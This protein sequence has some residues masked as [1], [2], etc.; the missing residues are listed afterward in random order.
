MLSLLVKTVSY[1]AFNIVAPQVDLHYTIKDPLRCANFTLKS[2]AH[3]QQSNPVETSEPVVREWL[4]QV[5]VRFKTYCLLNLN[6]FRR[7]TQYS[8]YLSSLL[9]TEQF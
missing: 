2:A 9:F 4:T 7:L 1:R 5:N 8:L 3:L 6:I